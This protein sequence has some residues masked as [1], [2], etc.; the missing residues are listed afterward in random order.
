MLRLNCKV[1]PS[2]SESAWV[3]CSGHLPSHLGFR[4]RQSK[5]GRQRSPGCPHLPLCWW[6][7]LWAPG[8]WWLSFLQDCRL[9]ST[10]LHG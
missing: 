2:M 8:T 6:Q 7:G 1:S 9:G 4:A 10:E 5:V 3:L